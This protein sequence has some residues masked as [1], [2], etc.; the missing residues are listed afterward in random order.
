MARDLELT[1]IGTAT[2]LFRHG[3]FTVLTD[4]NFLH[5]GDHVY[6]ALPSG[7]PNRG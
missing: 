5:A 3:D 6:L 7:S 4:P 2:T 1:F